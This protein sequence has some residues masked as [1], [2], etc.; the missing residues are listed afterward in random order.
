MAS[1]R[2]SGATI[3]KKKDSFILEFETAAQVCFLLLINHK[4]TLF[5]HKKKLITLQ[6]HPNKQTKK[7]YV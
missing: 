3:T 1:L 7:I 6:F 4:I 2:V 5:G